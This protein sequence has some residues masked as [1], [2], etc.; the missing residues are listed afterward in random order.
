MSLA[1]AATALALVLSFLLKAPCGDHPVSPGSPF[2]R[3]CYSDIEPFVGRALAPELPYRDY[4]VEYPVLTGLFIKAT[5][6]ILRWLGRVGVAP[7]G[8]NAFLVSALL[9]SPFALAT[10]VLL[11]P[12]VR[13]ER[14]LLWAAGPPLVLHAFL[15]WDLIAVAAAVWGV[16]A[17]EDRRPATGGSALALGASAKLFPIFFL[18]GAALQRWADRDRRG[19]WRAIVAF[20]A[21]AAVVNV[22][23][24]ILA[25]RGWLAIW[26]FHAA[27][28][29]DITS[30]WVWIARHGRQVVS[31]GWWDGGGYRDVAGLLGL[32]GF[33]V[34]SGAFLLRGWRRRSEPQGYPLAAT[35]LG[36]MG[37][38]LVLSK[39]HSPQYSLWVLPFLA[40]LDV[41]WILVGASLVADA[42]VFVV[43]FGWSSWWGTGPP[44]G[45]YELAVLSRAAALVALVWWAWRAN[46]L[47]PDA[48]SS[49][50]RS[51]RG[52]P[53]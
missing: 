20:V 31:S 53:T 6:V 11:R 33:A 14:L 7:T 43:A 12:R 26:R 38:F 10:T 2:P 30:I 8:A 37:L 47:L 51:E 5:A 15:N 32:A 27:R 24:L 1:L 13:R 29:P 16:V 3:F 48:A 36:I 22:P 46:R 17:M 34:G 35:S 21:V 4:R 25:P 50:H 42:M 23:W 49:T 40:L 39:V 44:S 45:A 9:L 28:A 52:H 41:P 19:T 18:P